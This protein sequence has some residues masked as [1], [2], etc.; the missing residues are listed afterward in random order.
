M[1]TLPYQSEKG[2]RGDDITTVHEA[3][4]WLGEQHAEQRGSG[5]PK[6]QESK[7]RSIMEPAQ[8]YVPFSSSSCF[9]VVLISY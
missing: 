6:A 4:H 3:G 9:Q 8:M 1:D 2:K 7:D 5:A